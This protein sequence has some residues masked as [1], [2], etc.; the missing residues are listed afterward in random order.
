MNHVDA[1]WLSG[2]H[3]AE[4]AVVMLNYRYFVHRFP[5]WL[6]LVIGNSLDERV[7]QL[8]IPNLIE[9]AGTYRDVPS[10]LSL[11]NSLMVSCGWDATSLTPIPA[12]VEC[13]QWFFNTMRESSTEC[14]LAALGPGTEDISQDFLQPLE[15]A[16]R[17]HYGDSA[18]YAYFDAHRPEVEGLHGD[19]I[20]NALALI[21]EDVKDKALF[22]KEVS[23][24]TIAAINKHQAFWDG[25]R[26]SVDAKR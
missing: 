18:D 19:D 14:A 26:R 8:L 10:H 2:T 5:Q 22:H 3:R 23:A 15:T 24:S 16:I 4:L 20:R 7:R 25:L 9:E 21:E 13:E 17:T 12:T 6:A 1:A 11:L